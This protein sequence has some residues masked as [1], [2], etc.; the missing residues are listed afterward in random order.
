[1]DRRALRQP[2]FGATSV[3]SDLAGRFTAH[4]DGFDVQPADEAELYLLR[5][6][7][8]LWWT[9]H[10]VDD[11]APEPSPTPS[12]TARPTRRAVWLPWLGTGPP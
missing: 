9:A 8:Y 7:H 2:P 11:P 5:D 3:V 1:M 12:P 4:F 6:G 10:G